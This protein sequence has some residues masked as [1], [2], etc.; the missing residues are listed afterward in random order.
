MGHFQI[1]FHPPLPDVPQ[2]DA[3]I[4]LE[5]IDWT[6]VLRAL[7]QDIDT[8]YLIGDVP[9][10]YYPT[11]IMNVFGDL[12]DEWQSFRA[13][14][15]HVMCLCGYPVLDVTFAGER[16]SFFHSHELHLGDARTPIAGDF[17]A[18]DVEQT[19]KAALDRVWSVIAAATL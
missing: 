5:E 2:T 4:A 18:A 1:R 15:P 19:F 9:V 7:P 12:Y 6:S 11:D 17:N 8:R 14:E 16:A 3:V 13:R 10:A